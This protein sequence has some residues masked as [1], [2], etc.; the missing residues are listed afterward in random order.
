MR[1]NVSVVNLPLLS[2]TCGCSLKVSKVEQRPNSSISSHSF[3]LL[4]TEIIT[5]AA[6]AEHL[7]CAC[8]SFGEAVRRCQEEMGGHAKLVS[9]L[10]EATEVSK[11]S[12]WTPNELSSKAIAGARQCCFSGIVTLLP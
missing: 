5:E 3:P 7:S 6:P 4:T 2:N 8:K 9:V 12:T 1:V 11:L 10:A